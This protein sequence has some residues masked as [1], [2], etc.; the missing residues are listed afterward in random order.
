VWVVRET[1]RNALASS[2]AKFAT[3]REALAHIE[4][5]LRLPMTEYIARS[6]IL[7]QRRISD[8]GSKTL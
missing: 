7:K 3:L 8:F 4:S 2:P 1:A 6:R 5:K